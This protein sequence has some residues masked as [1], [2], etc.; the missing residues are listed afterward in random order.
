MGTTVLM[1]LNKLKSKSPVHFNK[2]LNIREVDDQIKMHAEEI[3]VC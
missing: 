3:H 2:L 1:I